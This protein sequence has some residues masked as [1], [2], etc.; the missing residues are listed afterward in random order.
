MRL[1]VTQCDA[2]KLA[3]FVRFKPIWNPES[4]GCATPKKN[5]SYKFIIFPNA[6]PG[7]LAGWHRSRIMPMLASI[8]RRFVRCPIN[9]QI[10]LVH[11]YR[12]PRRNAGR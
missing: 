5:H 12:T 1:V 6:K 8:L 11:G 3:Y 4:S 10:T 9:P 2:Y 7:R